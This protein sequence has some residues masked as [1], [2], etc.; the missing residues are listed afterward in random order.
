[1]LPGLPHRLI[2]RPGVGELRQY[3]LLLIHDRVDLLL[4]LLLEMQ[5]GSPETCQWLHVARIA[6]GD[7]LGATER[8][9]VGGMRTT[10][11]R[12]RRFGR[13]AP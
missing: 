7:R 5:R 6:G 9:R 11:G 3:D 12:R 4:H 8:L 2:R 1:M 13:R 10:T